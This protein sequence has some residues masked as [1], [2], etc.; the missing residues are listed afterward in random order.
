MAIFRAETCAHW[1][2]LQ[3]VSVGDGVQTGQQLLSIERPIEPVS[4]F[5]TLLPCSTFTAILLQCCAK[6]R[7]VSSVTPNTLGFFSSGITWP[8]SFTVDVGGAREYLE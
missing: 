4:P 5:N 8:A 3:L 1:S 2:R 7:W 6:V